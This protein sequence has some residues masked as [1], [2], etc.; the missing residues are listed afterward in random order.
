MSGPAGRIDAV[1]VCGG[2][3][4]DFDYARLRLLTELATHERVRTRVFE[5]YDCAD[6]LAAADLLITY[7]CNVVPTADQRTALSQFL[8]RG[9]R[10]L[11][12]H[13]TNAAIA[14]RTDGRFATPRVLGELPRL[15]GSQFLGHPPIAPYRVELAEPDHPFLHGISDFEVTDELYISELHPPLRVLAHTRFVGESPGFEEGHTGADEPRPVL[16]LKQHGAGTVCYFTLGHCR[17]RFD[18][19]DLGVDDLGTTDRGSWTVPEF[20]IVVSRCVAWAVTGVPD[21][22]IVAGEA[23]S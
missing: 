8:R 17:G 4:H 16:Y 13:A 11:A 19:Q 20:S 14:R 6:A 23:V 10:W 15:L 22:A 21:I 7:T 3:W 5:T 1:L 9:G 12:L 2:Q 18:L